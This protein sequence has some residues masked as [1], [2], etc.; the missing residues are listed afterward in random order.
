MFQNEHTT[1]IEQIIALVEQLAKPQ[2]GRTAFVVTAKGDE[3]KTA[4][5]GRG[6]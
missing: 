2:H 5:R 3:V 6:L 1:S 4:F